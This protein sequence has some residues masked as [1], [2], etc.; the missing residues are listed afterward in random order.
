[1][2]MTNPRRNASA[3]FAT[4]VAG[5]L[6]MAGCASTTNSVEGSGS[7]DTNRSAAPANSA[8]LSKYVDFGELSNKDGSLPGYDAARYTPKQLMACEPTSLGF[9]GLRERK[10]KVGRAQFGKYSEPENDK[11]FKNYWDVWQEEGSTKYGLSKL[12]Q[13]V[14]TALRPWVS[15]MYA[16]LW[17]A[18][19]YRSEDMGIPQ[20]SALNLRFNDLGVR[21]GYGEHIAVDAKINKDHLDFP[22]FC[23][24]SEQM[25]GN[26]Y[27]FTTRWRT[28]GVKPDLFRAAKIPVDLLQP[29]G[30]SERRLSENSLSLVNFTPVQSEFG[31]LPGWP[32]LRT[33]DSQ[34]IVES[35]CPAA[36]AVYVGCAV[37]RAKTASDANDPAIVGTTLWTLPIR[38]EFANV[39]QYPAVVTQSSSPVSLYTTQG[40]PKTLEGSSTTSP[41]PQS[42]GAFDYLR[43]FDRGDQS[44][45]IDVK[46]AG[47][48]KSF[49]DFSKTVSNV[50]SGAQAEYD[51]VLAQDDSQ[52][53]ACSKPTS[54]SN[55]NCGKIHVVVKQ[56]SDQGGGNQRIRVQCQRSGELAMSEF[57]LNCSDAGFLS[58]RAESLSGGPDGRALI[59]I[60]LRGSVEKDFDP[61]QNAVYFNQAPQ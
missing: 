10:L 17:P 11:E 37:A 7:D 3:V 61:I 38:V 18:Y 24:T 19:T 47:Q 42:I 23:E 15:G 51:I 1:M 57:K 29:Q 13:P 25:S 59:R 54:E 60:N 32:E 2:T 33:M 9:R 40:K 53:E 34:G 20:A 22:A 50:G 31:K 55:P 30:A 41:G 46:Q 6:L 49:D 5:S 52:L 43:A 27:R 4:V 58:K 8:A 16:E 14:G 21:R 48:D 56:E 39:T 12:P 28:A 44:T 26:P 45:Q 35:T 36:K